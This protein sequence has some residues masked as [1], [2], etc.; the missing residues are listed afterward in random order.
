MPYDPNSEKG[1]DLRTTPLER[2]GGAWGPWIALAA[3]ILVAAFAWTQWGGTA[4]D[5]TSTAST[6]P[7]ISRSIPKPVIPVTPPAAAPAN[8][9]TGTQP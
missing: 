9:P 1:L 8:P 2:R 4:T 5:P 6:T 7:P 3:I